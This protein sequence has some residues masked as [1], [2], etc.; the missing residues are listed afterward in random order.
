MKNTNLPTIVSGS[1]DTILQKENSLLNPDLLITFG[2]MSTSKALI[3]FLRKN[4]PK[5]H[6]H[7]QEDDK[8]ID[9]FQSITK[10][11]K[12]TPSKLFKQVALSTVN[13]IFD[14][15]KEAYRFI[16][17]NNSE[18]KYPENLEAPTYLKPM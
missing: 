5:E 15:K 13:Y 8:I 3:H 6:W 14:S 2:E 10:V 9:T 16:D 11:I 7:I 18:K 17:F 12:T 4:K 1:K